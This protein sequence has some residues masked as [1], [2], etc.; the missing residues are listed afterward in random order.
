MR[1]NIPAWRV[2]A[3]GEELL[4]AGGFWGRKSVFCKGVT[5]PHLKVR[6]IQWMA[7]HAWV[8]GMHKLDSVGHRKIK[9]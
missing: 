7:P 9:K 2:L 5:P 3:A 6:H 8:C 4:T 1:K